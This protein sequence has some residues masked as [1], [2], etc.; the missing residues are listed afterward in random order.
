[1]FAQSVLYIA[2]NVIHTN[3]PTKEKHDDGKIHTKQVIMYNGVIFLEVEF[4]RV[5]NELLNYW[6]TYKIICIKP[7]VA[8]CI[9]MAFAANSGTYVIYILNA[10]ISVYTASWL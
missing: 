4:L 10:A 6:F 7:L 8:L 2:E 3:N 5:I 9:G 1:M